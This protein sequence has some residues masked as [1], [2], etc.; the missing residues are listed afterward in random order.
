M[1]ML[2]DLALPSPFVL[3]SHLY[4]V[5]L[6]SFP[7]IGVSFLLSCCPGCLP[8]GHEPSPGLKG[9]RLDVHWTAGYW[10]QQDIPRTQVSPLFPLPSPPPPPQQAWAQAP[11]LSL[12]KEMIPTARCPKGS[13]ISECQLFG[14]NVCSNKALKKKFTTAVKALRRK[15]KEVL[16]Y[17]FSSLFLTQSSN[18]KEKFSKHLQNKFH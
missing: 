7:V 5:S 9:V 15:L 18:S 10:P 14:S 4:C 8:A 3:L 12:F 11:S 1:L 13:A 16:V 6:Q 2:L 17:I